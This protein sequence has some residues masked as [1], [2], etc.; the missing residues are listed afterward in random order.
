MSDEKKRKKKI[1]C[2]LLRYCMYVCMGYGYGYGY[3]LPQSAAVVIGARGTALSVSY[4]AI[5]STRYH[6]RSLGCL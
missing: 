3:G 5:V 6:S 1:H 4:T 2:Y